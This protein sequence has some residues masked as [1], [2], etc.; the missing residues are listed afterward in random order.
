[1]GISNRVPLSQSFKPGEVV[2]VFVMEVNPEKNR[3]LFQ[4]KKQK[5][6]R[7]EWITVVI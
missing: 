1:T 3:F 5:R 7:K 6:F 2:D 4:F